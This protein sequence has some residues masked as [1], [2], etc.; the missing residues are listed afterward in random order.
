MKASGISYL[1]LVLNTALEIHYC[2][3]DCVIKARVHAARP[4][5]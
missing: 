1:I 4:F 5:P 3:L 2:L